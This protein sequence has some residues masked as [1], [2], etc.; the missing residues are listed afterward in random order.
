MPPPGALGVTVPAP[1]PGFGGPPPPGFGAPDSQERR[2]DPNDG[3]GPFTR[4][5]F[6]QHYGVVKGAEVWDRA[7]GVAAGQ[8]PGFGEPLSAFEENR[9]AWVEQGRPRQSSPNVWFV[10]EK[11]ERRNLC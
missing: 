11:E 8:L 3:G 5:E 4:A 10:T 9:R 1:P 6:I 7:G 2:Q